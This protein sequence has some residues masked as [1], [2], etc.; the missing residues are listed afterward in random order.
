LTTPKAAIPGAQPRIIIPVQPHVT[1]E[2]I[3][4][5]MNWLCARWLERRHR[6]C[7]GRNAL[8]RESFTRTYHQDRNLTAT[9]SRL[10][11]LLP[12]RGIDMRMSCAVLLGGRLEAPTC[13]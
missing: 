13:L 9:R 3:A 7:T 10:R 6:R 8:E 12:E 5:S 1:M 2:Q 11:R 4:A